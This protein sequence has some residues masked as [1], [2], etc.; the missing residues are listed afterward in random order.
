MP[1]ITNRIK[2]ASLCDTQN[3]F[4]CC[5]SWPF[6]PD[7]SSVCFL[8][9]SQAGF[10]GFPVNTPCFLF[11]FLFFHFHTF[12]WAASP[13]RMLN[14]ISLSYRISQSFVCP[15]RS[16][17]FSSSP[18]ELFLTTT[19]LPSKTMFY[20]F[21]TCVHTS[22]VIVFPWTVHSLRVLLCFHQ[23]N[24]E[25]DKYA[26]DLSWPVISSC[27]DLSSPL[28]PVFCPTV[29]LA[30]DMVTCNICIACNPKRLG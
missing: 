3:F 1:P 17:Q 16:S 11:L 7:L 21:P 5:P 4:C 14:F 19:C 25:G 2:Y 29:C 27:C 20:A 23:L 9:F 12:A 13:M 26:F 18:V 8:L 15:H 22:G 24:L 6:Y 10:L 28:F 30:T